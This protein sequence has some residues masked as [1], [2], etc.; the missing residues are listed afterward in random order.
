MWLCRADRIEDWVL[1]PGLAVGTFSS[2]TERLRQAHLLG[3][4][5][6]PDWST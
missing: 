2:S 5:L 4:N 3:M 1:T 6:R